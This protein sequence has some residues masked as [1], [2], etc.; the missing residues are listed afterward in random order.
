[1]KMCY[2]KG[3]INPWCDF[4]NGLDNI[5]GRNIEN[6]EKIEMIAI[7]IPYCLARYQI[8]HCLVFFGNGSREMEYNR[9]FNFGFNVEIKS[10]SSVKF[11]ENL[12]RDAYRKKIREINPDEE[13]RIMKSIS[14]NLSFTFGSLAA[15]GALN[16]VTGKRFF[17]MKKHL[18]KTI[19]NAEL[20]FGSSDNKEDYVIGLPRFLDEILLKRHGFVVGKEAAKASGQLRT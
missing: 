19:I 18:L 2:L 9:C 4:C 8:D 14:S 16:S 11:T 6:A 7:W 5:L 12:V 1:M 20:S 17:T 13:E 3:R 10:R 15:S